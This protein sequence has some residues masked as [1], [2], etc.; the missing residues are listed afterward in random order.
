MLPHQLLNANGLNSPVKI[1]NLVERIKR[2]KQQPY[3]VSKT[4]S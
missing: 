2:N 3:S 4:L 1:Y